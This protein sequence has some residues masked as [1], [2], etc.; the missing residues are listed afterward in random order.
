M[1]GGRFV[2]TFEEL[3][4]IGHPGGG[5]LAEA[6]ALVDTGSHHSMMPD[7]LLRSL[8]IRPNREGKYGFADGSFQTLGVADCRIRIGGEVR[9]C[10]VIFGPD[11]Q[12]ILGATTLEIFEL[13]VD[14]VEQRLSPK[15]IIQ[16][17]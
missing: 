6:S 5:D 15:S 8:G 4:G 11:D 14:P 7:S 16:H 17:G 1:D 3:V 13:M 10:P 9:Y 12:H 2:G